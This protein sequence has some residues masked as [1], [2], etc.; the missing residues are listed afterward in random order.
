MQ[1]EY[2]RGMETVKKKDNIRKNVELEQDQN[3]FRPIE[4]QETNN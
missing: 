1:M 3:L 4:K 2:L